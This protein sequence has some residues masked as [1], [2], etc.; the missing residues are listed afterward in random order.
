MASPHPNMATLMPVIQHG[1][2]AERQRKCFLCGDQLN[3]THQANGNELQ[4]NKLQVTHISAPVMRSLS[5]PIRVCS[6]SALN[7]ALSLWELMSRFR[8]CPS[9][10]FGPAMIKTSD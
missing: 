7:S 3:Q 5:G 6:P 2:D 1:R 9:T 10:S 4:V 8:V